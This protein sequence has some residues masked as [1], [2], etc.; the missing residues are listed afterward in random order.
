MINGRDYRLCEESD[1]QEGL[2]GVMYPEMPWKIEKSGVMI[3]QGQGN[4]KDR[5]TMYDKIQKALTGE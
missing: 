2:M 5:D 1:T 4:K 3:A